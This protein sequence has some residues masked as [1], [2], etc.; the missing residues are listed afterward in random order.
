MSSA[1][2]RGIVSS[3]DAQG[4]HRPTVQGLYA[5]GIIDNLSLAEGVAL[6]LNRANT[7]VKFWKANVRIQC[8]FP[9]GYLVLPIQ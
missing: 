6:L 7:T 9:E 8:Q 5:N 2:G 4:H 3:P 1:E